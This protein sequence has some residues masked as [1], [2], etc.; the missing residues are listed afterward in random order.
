MGECRPTA[1]MYEDDARDGFLFGCAIRNTHPREDTGGLSFVRCAIVEE[2][3][4]PR[5]IKS[6]SRVLLRSTVINGPWR[7]HGAVY[8][9][10]I[11]VMFV[12]VLMVIKNS[13]NR[14]SRLPTL[15]R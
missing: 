13:L 7:A 5:G 8:Q 3:A 9:V 15:R 2:G 4:D 11:K 12:K 10:C 1:A 14:M 6:G